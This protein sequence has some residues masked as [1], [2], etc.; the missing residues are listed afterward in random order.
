MRG[1]HF[2][3]DTLSK[4]A[5]H[6]SRSVFQ[7]VSLR[8]ILQ[9]QPI[10]KKTILR[11]RSSSVTDRRAPRSCPRAPSAV[12]KPGD[13]PLSSAK[14]RAAARALIQERSRPT[15]PPWGTLNLSF[16]TVEEARELYAKVRALPGEHLIGT[17]WFPVR[18]PDG[19]KPGY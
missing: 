10:E 18:W 7:T 4:M 12:P 11:L 5:G 6:T 8:L 14:S 16:L 9:T 13:F 1:S 19:F 17:P 3:R 2:A 15:P